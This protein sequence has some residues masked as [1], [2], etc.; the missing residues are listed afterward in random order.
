MFLCLCCEHFCKSPCVRDEKIKM[1]EFSEGYKKELEK[2]KK[3]PLQL[4]CKVF[5]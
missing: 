3:E 2:L 1:Q 5:S 4:T